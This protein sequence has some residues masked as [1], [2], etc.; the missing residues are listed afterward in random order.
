MHKHG[1]SGRDVF[2]MRLA[3]EEAIVNAVKHGNAGDP[4]KAVRVCCHVTAQEVR[5]EVED[6]G[7]GFDPRRLLDPLA[8][9][10]LDRPCGR[11]LLLMRHYLTRICYNERG[12]V[13]ILCKARSDP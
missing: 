12:N 11:G 5:A 2:A 4:S 10:N 13:V 9:E 8:V 7:P 3:L 1:Y 6:E